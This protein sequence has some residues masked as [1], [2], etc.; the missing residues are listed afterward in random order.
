MKSIKFGTVRCFNSRTGEGWITPEDGGRDIGV[1][2]AAVLHA[3]LGQLAEGQTLGFYVA[4]GNR[5]AVDL[6]ATWSNR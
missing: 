3:G 4:D 5:T 6:W 1:R 2:Q